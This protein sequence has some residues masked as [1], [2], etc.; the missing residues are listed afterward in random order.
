W[1][2]V[3]G[4]L[5]DTWPP[6]SHRRLFGDL[7]RAPAPVRNYSN[8]VEVVSKDP[9]AD[10]KRILLSFA[11]RA[12]RRAVTDDDVKPFVKLV[13]SKLEA[14][15]SFEQAMRV[16]LLAVMLSPEF[17][18]LREKRGQLD[19]FALASRLSYFIWSTMPDDELLELAEKKQLRKP[20][21]L[22]KQ[23]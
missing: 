18:F 9:E 1:V 10:A 16:G 22:H 14:K 7:K 15:H 12:F 4:P 13:K 20:D 11:R 19:D 23:V 3:E 17:L 2:E 21:I 6:P 8:R 5:H